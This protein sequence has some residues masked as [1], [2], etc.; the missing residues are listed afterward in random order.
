MKKLFFAMAL[1]FAAISQS[2]AYCYEPSFSKRAPMG[3][4][5]LSKPT[6]PYCMNSSD[7]CE[8]Y[9]IRSYV[10]SVNRYISQLNELNDEAQEFAQ[11]AIKYANEVNEFASCAAKDAK[12]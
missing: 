6:K 4:F 3:S 9:E 5:S 8:D 2:W 1:C 11:A 7:G 10:D 12:E